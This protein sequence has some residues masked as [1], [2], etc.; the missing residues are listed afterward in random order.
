MN[1]EAN[2]KHNIMDIQT[3]IFQTGM[4]QGQNK[5]LPFLSENEMKELNN[6]GYIGKNFKGERV[7][8]ET[9]LNTLN[10]GTF[11]VD[12]TKYDDGDF[13]ECFTITRVIKN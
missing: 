4:G 5:D 9:F 3:Y 8:R 12:Q 11:K 6:I 1:K 13:T 7:Y 2:N 10:K